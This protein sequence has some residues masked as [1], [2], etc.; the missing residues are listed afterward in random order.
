MR[1]DSLLYNGYEVSPFYDS[2]V[3]KVIVHAP[4]RLEA[5]R[6]MRRVLEEM[7]IEGYPTTADFCHLILHHPDF[8]KGKYDTGF[9]AQ[10]QDELLRWNKED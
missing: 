8:V 3:A 2:L 7:I 5:I 1:V 4:T 10:H 6:R 9:L